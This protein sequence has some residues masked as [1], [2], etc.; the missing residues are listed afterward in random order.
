MNVVKSALLDES[1]YEYDHPSG[2]KI[3]VYPKEG[4]QS[5]YAIFGTRYGSID[6]RFRL[7]GEQEWTVVPEG[8]A[9]FL[10]HKLFESQ[11]E[12]AFARYART[13]ANANAFTSFDRTC[14]L[15]SCTEN[16]GASLEILLDF[17]QSPYFTKETVDKEQGIIGQEIRM[18][19][20]EPNWRVM[21][22]LLI[23]LY[24]T[25]PVRIDIAG[26]VESIAKIDADLLYKC[27]RTFY[28]LNNMVLAVAGKVDPKEVLAIA[29]KALKP[30]ADAV[31]ER[32]FEEEPE[33][34][35]KDHV[36]QKLSVSVPLFMF[37]YKETPKAEGMDTQ[38]LVEWELLLELIAG[39]TSPLYRR[40]LDEQLINESFGTELFEGRGYVSAMFAGESKDPEAVAQAVKAEIERL[41]KDGIDKNAFERVRRERYGLS[42]MAFD[43]VEGIANNLSSAHFTGRGLFDT[44][45]VLSR[46]T[47]EQVQ[48]LLKESL[49]PERSAL[50][51]I[52][53]A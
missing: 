19:D 34:I 5:A 50:S 31:I 44:A 7:K 30:S 23:A 52:L 28:N 47:C 49:R 29:D 12:D 27:Y 22:N 38:T 35:V 37:G 39:K 2:L 6:T 18:Y 26:T 41:K 33:G 21:F 32:S 43:S 11:D 20:D 45:E 40:L 46:V 42:V 16:F 10:E 4:Y 1:Y 53:P 8:I 48:G 14:Y 13:G 3:L 24:H 9:H 17:V 15:F 36:E 25:H 51:T